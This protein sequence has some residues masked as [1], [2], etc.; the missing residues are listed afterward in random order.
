MKAHADCDSDFTGVR[1]RAGDWVSWIKDNWDTFTISSGPHTS[2]S[3]PSLHITVMVQG[4]DQ[5]H[6]LVSPA[7]S[8]G[9]NIAAVPYNGKLYMAIKIPSVP[10]R[11]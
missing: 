7:S 5:V 2:K 9:S 6:V 8:T 11:A 1:D 4:S 3:E 10:D